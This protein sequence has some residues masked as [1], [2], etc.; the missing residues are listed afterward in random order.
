MMTVEV[1]D[2]DELM[3]LVVVD[4]VLQLHW[5]SKKERRQY[6]RQKA[7]INEK[8]AFQAISLGMNTF[9]PEIESIHLLR[10][11]LLACLV[12]SLLL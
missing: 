7:P 6:V 12:Q 11:W 4:V 3:K 5:K 2:D 8:N 9:R 10:T 1:D